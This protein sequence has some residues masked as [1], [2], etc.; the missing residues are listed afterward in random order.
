MKSFFE[1]K[2]HIAVLLLLMLLLSACGK[3]EEEQPPVMPEET[4]KIV[5]STDVILSELMASNKTVLAD[6]DNAFTDW[7]ELYNA[8]AECSLNG[9]WFS[10]NPSELCKWQIPSL[11]IG[12][13]EYRVIF[14]SGK[15]SKNSELHCSFKLPKEGGELFFSDPNGELVWSVAYGQT[16]DDSVIRFDADEPVSTYEATPGF[17]NNDEG[18]ESFLAANDEHGALVINEAVA[19]NDDYFYHAG[20]YYDWVELKNVSDKTVKLSDYYLTDSADE[21]KLFRLPEYELAAGATYIVFC[22]ETET[23][24]V[25]VHAPFSIDAKGDELYLVSKDGTLSDR[26]G[27]RDIPLGYSKGRIDGASGFFFFEKRTPGKD[28]S[29]GLRSISD[30]VAASVEQGVYDGVASLTVELSANGTIYYTLNGSEPNL[31]SAVYTEPIT[32]SNTAVIRAV[33]YEDGCVPSECAT[34]SYIIN[35]GHTMPVMSIACKGTEFEYMYSYD[36]WHETQINCTLFDGEDS[37][38]SMGKIMLHGT[39]ARKVWNKKNFKIVF[40]DRYGGDVTYNGFE[41]TDCTEFHSILLR[42][43]DTL[44]MH[45]F[46]DEL[47]SLVAYDT[48]VVDP[49]TLDSKYC[50]LYVNGRY[51]GLFAM[52]EAYSDK[53]GADHTDSAEDGTVVCRAPVRDYASQ[54]LSDLIYFVSTHDMS[55]KDNYEYVS[56]LMDMQSYAQW[57]CYEVFFNNLDPTGNV[58]YVKGSNSG[59]KWQFALFD[60]DI[61]MANDFAS[62]VSLTGLDSQIT[63]MTMSMKKSDEFCRLL[64]ET[65]AQL[66]ENGMTSEHTLER[67]NA[68]AEEVDAEVERDMNRWGEYYECYYG[69]LDWQRKF[70]TSNRDKTFLEELQ[71]YTK[72][73]TETMHL[74]FPDSY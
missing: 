1:K 29:S 46:R 49:L 20:D 71:I 62:M 43:G 73:D 4:E 60:F 26:M 70:F 65:A 37:F 3:A 35:E 31:N 34:F 27:M 10:D 23:D 14:F 18:Y 2:Q 61:S 22:G 41:N 39:S 67:F 36:V 32:L 19:Y 38:S 74:Y 40:S 47:A 57:L 7:I 51:W 45:I 25:Y 68:M 69:N 6:C 5:Y 13:G 48:A 28:N 64:L 17:A 11:S 72:A 16:E 55:D 44:G 56:G 53:Y 42:G 9:Y 30:K 33:S 58:R 52:R 59:S 24:S 21:P 50:V 12:A 63:S 8:G 15:N 66:I 54:E